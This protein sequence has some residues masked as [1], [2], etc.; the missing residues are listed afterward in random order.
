MAKSGVGS[1]FYNE[2][3]RELSGVLGMF[4]ILTVEVAAEMFTFVKTCR[5]V[6]SI[7]QKSPLNKLD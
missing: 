4:F 2:G 1:G 3:H 7:L 6:Q 5:T